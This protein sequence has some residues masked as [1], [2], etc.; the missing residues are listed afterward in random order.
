MTGRAASAT[1]SRRMKMLSASSR[2]RWVSRLV[3]GEAFARLRTTCHLRRAARGLG[4]D[5]LT[6]EM[7]NGEIP[8]PGLG[9]DNARLRGV[10]AECA[11][12]DFPRRLRETRQRAVQHDGH[13]PRR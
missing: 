10:R 3:I 5:G 2:S 1:V 12:A 13:Q 9:G 7:T 8:D 11:Q 4:L 6:G